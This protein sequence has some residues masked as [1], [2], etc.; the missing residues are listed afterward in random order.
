[1]KIFLLCQPFPNEQGF[2]TMHSPGVY[3]GTKYFTDNFQQEF[4][5]NAVG[6]CRFEVGARS[7]SEQIEDAQRRIQ[8][9]VAELQR[10]G[11][12]NPFGIQNMIGGKK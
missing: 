9:S 1:M 2:F 10:L 7:I 6:S 4:T 3:G 12:V 5:I 8:E 11:A